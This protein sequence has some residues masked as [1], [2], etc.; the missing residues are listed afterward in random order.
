M[1]IEKSDHLC[2]DTELA[3]NC[4]LTPERCRRICRISDQIHAKKIDL[5]CQCP[6][7]TQRVLSN[8]MYHCDLPISECSNNNNTLLITCPKDYICRQKRCVQISAIVRVNKS[9]LFLPFLLIALLIG[10]ILIIIIL[11]I[12]LIKMRSVRCIKFVHPHVLSIDSNSSSPTTI[13]RLSSKSTD[14][15]CEKYTK[16]NLFE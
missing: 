12:G 16:I 11:V 8:N 13:T 5:E 6:L 3:S 1:S 15:I 4:S 7:G 9:I 2:I 14:K 10:A